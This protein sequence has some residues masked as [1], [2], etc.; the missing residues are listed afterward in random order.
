MYTQQDVLDFIQ[1]ED[2]KFIRLAFFDLSGRQKNVSIMP[3]QLDR[4]FR[5]GISF[6]ASSVEGFQ[7]ADKSDLFLHPDPSTLTIIPWR[8]STGKVVRMFCDIQ[9]PDGRPYE[10]DSR[11]ILKSAVALARKEGYEFRVGTEMEFYLFK[12]DSDG[13]PTRQPFDNAGYM[14][15]AP[16]DKGENIRRQICLTLEKM[17]ISPESSHHEEGPG[18]NEI[19]YRFADAMK[20][21]DDAMAFKTVVKTVAHANGLCADFSPKPLADK[22][23]NGFHINL[24]VK[25]DK[26]HVILPSVIA[27]ILCHIKAMTLFLNPA[28]QSYRRFGSSKAPKYIS[29]SSENRSQLVRI[30]AATGVYRRAELRSPDPLAN[31]YL[32]FTLMIRAG[33]FGYRNGLYLPPVSDINLF[34]ADES[35]TSLYDRLPLSIEEARSEARASEFIA[36]HLPERILD[37]YCG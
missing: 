35:V 16:D 33:L 1:E 21:A 2:V 19:D 17:G 6:D 28:E 25:S 9:Y 24:S 14:D 32:A 23:G 37:I 13:N 7:T 27:G 29:W 3:G 34:S 30:P 4:A 8:P 11:H 36:E 22:P 12:L 5:D 20:A 26:N 31:P 15:I 10:K 18:Q